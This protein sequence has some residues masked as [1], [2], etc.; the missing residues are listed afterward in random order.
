MTGQESLIYDIES[1]MQSRGAS[2]RAESLRSVTDLFVAQAE[3]LSEE[4][5]ALFDDVLA[6]LAA[7]IEVGARALL[8][9][10]LASIP[11][12]PRRVIH[13]LAFDDEIEVACPVL[14]QSE[15]LSEEALVEN[16]R[17]K[18]QVH[19]L[20]I[21]KR[22]TITH[23]VTDVLVIR[24][25]RTVVLSAI[26][27]TGAKFS[28]GG[29]ATLVRRSQGDEQ[30]A[31]GVGMRAEIPRHHFLKLLTTASRTVRAKLEQANPQAA[32]EIRR[33]V[34]EVTIKTQ[35]Q[36]IANS[37]E[38]SKARNIVTARCVGDKLK[39]ADLNDFASAGKFEETVV[40]LSIIANI[41]VAMVERALLQERTELLLS[42][43]KCTSLTWSEVKLILQLRARN[44]AMAAS[45]MDQCLASY[46]RLKPTTA[47]LVVDFHCRPAK[48]PAS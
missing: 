43:L 24:G 26:G 42:I 22:K 5:V 35:V 12:A 45:D 1:V 44:Y 38:Y 34:R 10:R 20:A 29:Y 47:R 36:S 17:S 48:R 40:A 23:A 46:E 14:A 32:D 15:C 8:A 13:S 9:K 27:N 37:Y 11:N 25:D 28:D 30:I 6:R 18:S 31:T 19:L 33:V 4:Q 21:S 41:P 2:Q 7:Q 16:A 39:Q 3:S